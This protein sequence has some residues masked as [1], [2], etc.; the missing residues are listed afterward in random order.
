MNRVLYLDRRVGADVQEDDCE[1]FR[2]QDDARPVAEYCWW[3]PTA[4]TLTVAIAANL[5]EL[6][7]GG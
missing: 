5:K 4:A 3:P 2:G 7:Y 1:L 6:G